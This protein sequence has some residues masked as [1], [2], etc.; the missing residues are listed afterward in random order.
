MLVI[1]KSGG[2]LVT[3]NTELLMMLDDIERMKADGKSTE[4]ILKFLRAEYECCQLVPDWWLIDEFKLD[5]NEE[6]MLP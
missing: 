3:T 6:V 1:A 5:K 2:R 4:R